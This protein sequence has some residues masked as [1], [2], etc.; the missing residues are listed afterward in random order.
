MGPEGLTRGILNEHISFDTIVEV[1]PGGRDATTRGI[2]LGLIGDS[3]KHTSSWEF[4][5]FRNRLAKDPVTD[6]WTIQEMSITRQMVA[7]YGEGW[8]NGGTLSAGSTISPP[9]FLNPIRRGSRSQ[10]PK[11]WQPS[12][13]STLNGTDGRVSDL[14]RR[15][16]RSA[17][18]DETENISGAYGYFADD[19]RCDKFAA[20]HAQKGFKESPGTG[21]YY[22]RSGS[23]RPA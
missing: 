19:I 13:A 5:I 15:L 1:A 4:S 18:V 10:R 3:T 14:D 11:D 8:G 20:L 6:I 9:A 23:H 21:W 22:S 12:W 17:A 2:D 7:N 16:A